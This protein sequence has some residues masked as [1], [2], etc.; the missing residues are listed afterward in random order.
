MNHQIFTPGFGEHQVYNALAAFACVH[1]LGIGIK[2][3]ADQLKTFKNLPLHLQIENGVGGCIILNDT[4]NSN[5]TSLRAAFRALNGIAKGKKR[6]ALIGEIN[7][8]G[9]SKEE[10]AR[11]VGAMI[12]ELGVDILITYGSMSEGIAS[13]CKKCKLE[14]EVYVL[15][16][17]EDIYCLL[18][19]KLDKDSILLVKSS[20]FDTSIRNLINKFVVS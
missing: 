2:E 20:M 10:V 4:W 19:S 9:D 12:A 5:L 16:T 18:E 3:A 11:Q 7:A 17:I 6:I 15:P 13:Q 14:S 1:E 8:L